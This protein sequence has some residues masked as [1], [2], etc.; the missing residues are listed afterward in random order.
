MLFLIGGFQKLSLI[1]YP[2]KVAS[3]VFTQGCNFRCP[4]CHNRELV[5]PS[6]FRTPIPEEEVISFLFKRQEKIQGV[7][8]TG[9]EP[10]IQP[11]LLP[12]LRKIKDLGYL[13]KLDTNASRPQVISQLLTENLVDFFAVDIKASQEHYP[14]LA[15]VEVSIPDIRQSVDLILKSGVEHMFRTTVI[16][17]LFFSGDLEEIAKMIASARRYT[18]QQFV[19]RPS[20]LDPSLLDKAHLSEQEFLELKQK[21]ERPSKI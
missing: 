18:L 19:P 8:V 1:D 21:W 15:G 12:F 2:G 13:V 14:E 4:F 20:I 16:K 10:T 17:P 11:D 3:V 6:D 5:I 9:G 7:V